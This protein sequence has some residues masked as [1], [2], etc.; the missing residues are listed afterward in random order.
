MWC[1]SPLP[2]AR[3][4]LERLAIPAG[5]FHSNGGGNVSNRA[6]VSARLV[7]SCYLCA[8]WFGSGLTITCKPEEFALFNPPSGQTCL[9][10]ARDFVNAAGGY[11]DNPNDSD[12]CRYCQYSVSDFDTGRVVLYSPRTRS[13]TSFSCHSTSDI[14]IVG[15]TWE[16]TSASLVRSSTFL[17]GLDLI[18]APYSLQFH[19]NNQ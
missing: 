19:R 11:L 10:W 1:D 9:A 12:A 4:V 3:Q 7:L 5:S 15:G 16:F 2:Y 8:K 6:S 13:E 18:F 17:R 14:R